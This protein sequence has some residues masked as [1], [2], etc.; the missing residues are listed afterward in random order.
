MPSCCNMPRL[1]KFVHVSTILPEATRSIVIPV[2]VADWFVAG[3]PNKLPV[4]VPCAPQRVTT[5]SL[6]QPDPQW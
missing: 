2:M 5:L 4:L 1:S 6:R 3:M